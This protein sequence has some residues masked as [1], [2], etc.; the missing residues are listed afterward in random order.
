MS[1]YEAYDEAIRLDPDF[2]DA[3]NDKGIALDDQGKYD[4]AIRG[5]R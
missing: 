4:E 2:A 1:Q 5:L 3:W